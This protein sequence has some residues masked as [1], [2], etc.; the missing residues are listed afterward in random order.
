MKKYPLF[1]FLIICAISSKAQVNTVWKWTSA[2]AAKPSGYRQHL[3]DSAGNMILV[4]T[5]SARQNSLWLKFGSR[6]SLLKSSF[7]KDSTENLQII[8][9]GLSAGLV[10][11]VESDATNR[12]VWLSKISFGGDTLWHFEGLPLKAGY[13]NDSNQYG[14]FAQQDSSGH[15]YEVVETYTSDSTRS[16]IEVIRGLPDG[17]NGWKNVWQTELIDSGYKLKS[18]KAC[19]D[20]LG[21][22][23]LAGLSISLAKDTSIFIIKIDRAGHVAWKQRFNYA[24]GTILHLDDIIFENG[25]LT[26][27]ALIHDREAVTPYESYFS[28]LVQYDISG[29][30]TSFR[31]GDFEAEF[32]TLNHII[33]SR[34]LILVGYDFVPAEFAYLFSY[35]ANSNL[36][37]KYTYNESNLTYG[38]DAAN[39]KFGNYYMLVR[40][41]NGDSSSV[42]VAKFPPY[43]SHEPIWA[44]KIQFGK[45]DYPMQISV[46]DSG[47]IYFSGYTLDKDSQPHPYNGS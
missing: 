30:Q 5:S 13:A 36:S 42:V 33:N 31:A 15:I 16:H 35:D 12:H 40:E 27:I 6:G 19:L 3:V 14:L 26:L 32:V 24:N 20:S 46:D 29:K 47:F 11:S 10:Q 28:I 22:L 34:G 2:Y 43:S 37:Y 45:T 9:S 1:F 41:V 44:K 38:I 7:G 18:A 4:G 8:R 17:T 23:Y 21:N 39:D 25:Q